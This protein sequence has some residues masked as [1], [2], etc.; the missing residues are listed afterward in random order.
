MNR[1]LTLQPEAE[2]DLAA[3]FRWYESQRFGLGTE[4]MQCVEAVFD[5]IRETPQLYPVVYHS[6][7]QALV[8]RFPYVVCYVDD[9][10]DVD[11]IA[12][13]HGHRDPTAWQVRVEKPSGGSEYEG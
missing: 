2:A 12:V 7:R 4:F 6:V 8:R 11:V 10:D 9:G 1:R 13:F 5:R 3:A